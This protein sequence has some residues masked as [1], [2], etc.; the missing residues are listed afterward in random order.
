LE[1]DAIIKLIETLRGENGCPWD[2]K[3]T[4]QTIAIYL[5][6]EIFELVDAIES[7]DHDNVCEELGDVLFHILFLASLFREMGHFDI[8]DVVDVNT[9]KMTRRHPHVFGKDKV[10][11]AEDVRVRWHK[12][13]KKEKQHVPEAS[14]LDSVPVSLPSLMRAYRIS[15]RAAKAGFDWGDIS[16]VMKKVE[17]EWNELKTELKGLNKSSK[18]QDILALEFGDVLFT[19]VN[20]A[21]FAN[22]HPEIAL[23]GSTKKFEKRF[24]YM[25]RQISKRKRDM[26]SFSQDELNG[27]WEQAKSKIN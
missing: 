3:Q 26:E 7:G 27:L 20:V 22:I 25:E 6:E 1:I 12:I 13:K 19:L 10:G 11:S 8:K 5:A 24:R 15:E 23:K 2:K 14:I 4:P 9:E 18:D 16:G 21:R 17:E